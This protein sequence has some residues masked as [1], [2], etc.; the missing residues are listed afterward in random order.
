MA[1]K[2]GL[3]DVVKMESTHLAQVFKRL[4]V[5]ISHGN[6]MYLY[7]IEGHEYLD[8][9]SGI[10]VN[11][12]GNCHPKVVDAV[13]KQAEK[14][15]HT[16]NWYYTLPQL[17]LAEKLTSITGME[18]LFY[19][20]DGSGAVE[21]SFKLARKATGKKE[22]VAFKNSFHGRT[23]GSLSLT[24]GERYRKPF[25]PLVPGVRFADYG[26]M[27]SLK[28]QVT[29]DTAA[30]IVEP[31]QGEAGVNIPEKGFLSELREF[32]A[33]K[34][35]LLIVDECQTGF[36][37]TG[38]LFA[39]Q[40]ENVK[41]D[42]LV[43]AKALGGGFP[44]S[45]ALY[46]G[47]DFEAGQQGGTFNGNPLAC[48]AANASVD[49]ILGEKLSE[50]SKKMGGILLDV[51]L[52]HGLDARGMGLMIGFNVKDGR[53]TVMKLIRERVLTIYSGNTIRV[54]PPLIIGDEHIKLFS[55]SLKEVL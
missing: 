47:F 49:V 11:N 13:K 53:G 22:V 52:D 17:E 45:A 41:P 37:R 24:W 26:S 35:V 25:E 30:V 36:G 14:L 5:A 46:S 6:G 39:F 12:V 7:D 31:I 9:F 54:L 29:G 34:G 33:D 8:M 50:N 42:I 38:K 48:A 4:P 28:E 20:N 3:N 21:T 43:L 32:T 27:E 1:L 23:M 40:H 19:S 15:M 10:A 55:D 16:S 2:M 44:I 18:R 51:L